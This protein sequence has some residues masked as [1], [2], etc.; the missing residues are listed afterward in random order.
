MGF[1]SSLFKGVCVAVGTIVGAVVTLA[2]VVVDA[3]QDELRRRRQGTQS[4]EKLQSDIQNLNDEILEYERKRARD[5]WL[6]EN[7]L[8]EYNNLLEK[9][10]SIKEE[11]YDAQEVAVA[12]KVA[13]DSG[14]YDFVNVIE[15][16]SQIILFH[17][18][19]T[20]VGKICPHCGRQ[21]KIQFRRGISNPSLPDFFW[22]CTGYYSYPTCKHTELFIPTDLNL[23]TKVDRPEF[24]ITNEQLSNIT[25]LP[26]SKNNIIK[27]MNGAKNQAIDN[28]ICPVHGETLVVKEKHDADGLLD[29]YF[30]SCPRWQ[31]ARQGCEYVEKIKSPAQLAS[32]LES[33][34]GR[35]IL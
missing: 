17:A 6:N 25:L 22:G 13:Q 5:G 30:L 35:G 3:I 4:K 9:R 21:M 32:V 1:W 15:N 14:S 27:R 12:K 33:F 16:N 20:S 26:G 8:Y 23:F 34:Y 24:D 29:Q 19:Q 2:G 18:G 31:P 28:Y 10:N 11:Y 7:N